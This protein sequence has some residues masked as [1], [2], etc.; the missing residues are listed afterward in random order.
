MINSEQKGWKVQT[1]KLDNK[2]KYYIII[3]KFLTNT[4][5]FKNWNKKDK[6][7]T[8]LH[9]AQSEIEIEWFGRCPLSNHYV[10]YY[11]VRPPSSS[12]GF[13]R[14]ALYAGCC[15]L[16]IF[17]DQNQ[18]DSCWTTRNRRTLRMGKVLTIAFWSLSGIVSQ[19]NFE[20][21]E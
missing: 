13:C 11:T 14:F 19:Y 2:H 16:T 12:N 15:P 4:A 20:M 1:T 17:P 8:K 10:F 6:I 21:V 18:K 9:L 5:V 3:L 7:L